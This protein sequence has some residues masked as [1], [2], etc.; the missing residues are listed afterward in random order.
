MRRF[1]LLAFAAGLVTMASFAIFVAT[2]SSPAD[3]VAVIKQTHVHDDYYHPAGTFLVG[4]ST[5]HNLAQIGC[6]QANPVPECDTIINTG[7]SVRWVAPAP[8]AVNLHSVTECTDN[9]FSVCGAG[10]ASPNPIEDSGFRAQPGWPY[11]VQFN[12]AGTYYYRCEVHPA[13]MVGRVV[14]SFVAGS[15]GGTVDLPL[16]RDAS[17]A[18]PVSDDGSGT[19]WLPYALIAAI[20]LVFI[21]GVGTLAHKRIRNTEE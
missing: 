21:T 6:Q 17:N 20:G 11:Q 1:K 10:T 3:A 15:V 12:N 8:L 13:T 5:D 7:D 16:M 19:E 18:A 2:G 9:T 14:V 4:P